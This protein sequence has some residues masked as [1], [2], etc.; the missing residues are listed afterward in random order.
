MIDTVSSQNIDL[1]YWDTCIM[2]KC[3][4]VGCTHALDSRSMGSD[5]TLRL[6][7]LMEVSV[8]FVGPARQMLGKYLKS[9]HDFFLPYPV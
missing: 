2:I 5:L 7:V 9:G 6:S 8:V 4:Q 1:S 3:G